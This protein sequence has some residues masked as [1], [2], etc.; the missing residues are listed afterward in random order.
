MPYIPFLD[1]AI[2]FCIILEATPSGTATIPIHKDLFSSWNINIST[3]YTYASKN[4]PHI[5]P[6]NLTPLADVVREICPSEATDNDI[7]PLLVL[8]NPENQ[9]GAASIL[10]SGILQKIGELLQMNYFV[11]PS[12]IHEVLIYPELLGLTEKEL[13]E[14]IQWV[15]ET[16]VDPQDFLSDHA[17]YFDCKQGR[18]MLKP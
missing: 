1:L 15:N 2:V 11:I 14:T 10:Y 16:T 8:S 12:S 18:L 9:W 17:Y 13:N 6:P 5:F 7:G 3:L 4:G